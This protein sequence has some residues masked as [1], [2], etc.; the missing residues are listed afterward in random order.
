[1]FERKKYDSLEAASVRP[2]SV[3]NLSLISCGVSL[4]AFRSLLP[5]LTHL[6]VLRVGWQ[7]WTELPKELSE[8]KELRS[9][10]IL[11]TPIKLFPVFL[12]S[13]PCLAELTLRGTDISAIPTEVQD[14]RHLKHLD[15]SN[16]PVRQIPSELSNLS[17][18]RELRLADNGLLMLPTSISNM[19]KLRTLALAGNCFSTTEAQK[20]QDWFPK[21]VVSV[22]S[23][24]KM[25][26]QPS[27]GGDGK[28][29]PQP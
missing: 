8:L 23:K 11:N 20:I 26:V 22:W 21:E 3:W 5:Q 2:S 28:P 17:E 18:L 6:Q 4:D 12:S 14:F 9:F 1:M 27:V 13:C 29:A 19:R 7:A 16:N 10:T 15:F 25:V 24:D